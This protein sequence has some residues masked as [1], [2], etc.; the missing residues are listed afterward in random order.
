MVPRRGPGSAT[1]AI[2]YDEIG[3]MG[4]RPLLALAGGC[5]VQIAAIASSGSRKRMRG[6]W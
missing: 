1:G 2:G 6:A 5:G 4:Q 3:P